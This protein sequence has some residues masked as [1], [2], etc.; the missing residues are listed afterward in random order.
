MGPEASDG[1]SGL[2]ISGG[3][4]IGKQASAGQP[5]HPALHQDSLQTH[6]LQGSTDKPPRAMNEMDGG[7][8]RA[9]VVQAKGR[10]HIDGDEPPLQDDSSLAELK[11]RRKRSPSRKDTV[12]IEEPE[13][14]VGPGQYEP[15]I[16]VSRKQAPKYSW[17]ISK[18][19]RDET[20]SPTL[21]KQI[22]ENPGPGKYNQQQHS[23]G[24][25]MMKGMLHQET[26]LEDK[27]RGQHSY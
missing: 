20:T 26:V 23:I 19:I 22:L 10:H 5:P 13:G 21:N 3:S 6:T 9:P 12:Q 25:K 14:R 2:P 11:I 8:S 18:T 15:K 7:V 1:P 24:M 27:N 4:A 16:E 17:G